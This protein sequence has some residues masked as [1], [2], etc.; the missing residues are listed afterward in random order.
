MII[1]Y[2]YLLNAN[3]PYGYDFTVYPEVDDYLDYIFEYE[4]LER[5]EE[6]EHILTVLWEDGY[7][8][9]LEEKWPF[10]D[11]IKARYKKEAEE[12]CGEDLC[13]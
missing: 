10:R 9:H 1:H 3:E 11:Y 13:D 7:F 2:Q 12:K 6:A 5:T 4:G 8:R